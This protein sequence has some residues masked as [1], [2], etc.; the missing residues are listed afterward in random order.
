MIRKLDCVCLYTDD[1]EG[2]VA[3]YT[4]LG[5][6][7]GWRLDRQSSSGEPCLLIGLRFPEAQS[8]ELVLS[9]NPDRKFTEIELLVDDVRG[10]YEELKD[11]AA[12]RWVVAPTPLPQG[13]VAV[14]MAPDGNEFVLIGA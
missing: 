4:G 14:M 8:A 6:T 5:L 13:H 10:T 1:I 2:S 12:I 3:F 11:N 9:N 7:E